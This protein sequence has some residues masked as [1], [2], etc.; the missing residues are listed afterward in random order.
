MRS[1]PCKPSVSMTYAHC[2][3]GSFIIELQ[4][5]ELAFIVLTKSK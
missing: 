5:K 1:L 4:S 2:A 3:A